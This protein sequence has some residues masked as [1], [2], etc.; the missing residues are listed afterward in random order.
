MWCAVLIRNALRMSEATFL[1]AV[2]VSASM[3]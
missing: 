3:A 2:A 1:V